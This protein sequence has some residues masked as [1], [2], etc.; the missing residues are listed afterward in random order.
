MSLISLLY[1]V[2]FSF[3]PLLLFHNAHTLALPASAAGSN[4][5]DRQNS[6]QHESVDHDHSIRLEFVNLHKSNHETFSESQLA[7][8]PITDVRL[9]EENSY[10]GVDERGLTARHYLQFLLSSNSNLFQEFVA[11]SD[12]QKKSP[13]NTDFASSSSIAFEKL[14]LDLPERSTSYVS[15]N[16]MDLRNLRMTSSSNTSLSRTPENRLRSKRSTRQ[17]HQSAATHAAHSHGSLMMNACE[18]VSEWVHLTEA[19]DVYGN[20]V[21]VLDNI[22]VGVRQVFYETYCRRTGGAAGGTGQST[23]ANVRDVLNQ[24]PAPAPSCAGIDTTRYDSACLD[25]HA[26]VYGKISAV[27]TRGVAMNGGSWR[28]IKIRTSCNCGLVRK[29]TNGRTTGTS[30]R[31]K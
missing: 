20:I 25:G 23:T 2:T 5:H 17:N 11:S 13:P 27:D 28:L 19:E 10:K 29:R 8:G 1:I 18:R 14:D 6:A 16:S 21:R 15:K 7:K 12:V 26:Y 9:N 30:L 31:H 3:L 4:N 24:S 22:D